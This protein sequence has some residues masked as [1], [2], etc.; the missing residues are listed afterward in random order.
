MKLG[1]KEITQEAWDQAMDI[2]G[3]TP[4]KVLVFGGARTSQYLKE[5]GH[6]PYAIDIDIR[7]HDKQ[8][9]E[10]LIAPPVD[11]DWYNV[12]LVT[13][14]LKD[15][16]Y[17]LIICDG[18]G[19]NRDGLFGSIDLFKDVPIILEDTWRKRILKT[20]TNLAIK[21]DK[22]VTLHPGNGRIDSWALI[23]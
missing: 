14:W 23:G 1:S 9:Y 12:D 7:Y 6:E 3:P 8:G 2:L 17:S 19:S 4:N 11:G 20:A 5:A 16:T 10:Y 18:P 13:E 15:K 22:T 21:N